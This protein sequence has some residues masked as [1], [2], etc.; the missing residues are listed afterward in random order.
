MNDSEREERGVGMDRI[1]VNFN[2]GTMR[3]DQGEIDS[4]EGIILQMN[5]GKPFITIYNE[6][7]DPIAYNK[8]NIV[9]IC[10]QK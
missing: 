2:M 7:G 9:W 4:Y 5:N 6:F 3:I 1:K 8:N 10:E